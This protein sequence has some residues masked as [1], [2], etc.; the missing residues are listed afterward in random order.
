MCAKPFYYS[1]GTSIFGGTALAVA[2]GLDGVDSLGS[3]DA[4]TIYTHLSTL[5][6]GWSFGAF[7]FFEGQLDDPTVSCGHQFE[8]VVRSYPEF[9]EPGRRKYF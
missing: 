2:S 7:Y 8:S 4:A 1:F 5:L 3:L 6:Y 9:H